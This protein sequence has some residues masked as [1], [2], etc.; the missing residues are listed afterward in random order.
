MPE[1]KDCYTVEITSVH[2]KSLL[3]LLLEM[4]MEDSGAAPIS[5]LQHSVMIEP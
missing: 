2:S 4:I 1:K 5:G 3:A